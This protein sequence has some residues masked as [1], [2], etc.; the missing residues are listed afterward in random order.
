MGSALA[1][2]TEALSALLEDLKGLLHSW[3]QED[4]STEQGGYKMPAMFG[5]DS[6]HEVCATGLR[7][8][9][10]KHGFHDA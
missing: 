5:W 9:L 2:P 7:E 4:N 8:V 6:A 1:S 3:E 10:R